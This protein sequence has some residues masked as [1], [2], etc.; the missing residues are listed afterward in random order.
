MAL[1][2]T[3][4]HHKKKHG[5]KHHRRSSSSGGHHSSDGGAPPPSVDFQSPYTA[6]DYF[7][8]NATTASATGDFAMMTTEPDAQQQSAQESGFAPPGLTELVITQ[9]KKAFA[10]GTAWLT[11]GYAGGFELYNFAH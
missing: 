7:E 2:K 5:D 6:T 1:K 9:A 11:A 3:V 10:D 4:N 8:M